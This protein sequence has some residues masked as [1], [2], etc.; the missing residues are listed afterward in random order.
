VVGNLATN[1]VTIRVEEV[2]RLQS[3]NNRTGTAVVCA[4]GFDNMSPSGAE[5]GEER[6]L[7]YMFYR[8][9]DDPNDPVLTS[10]GGATFQNSIASNL[11]L[12]AEHWVSP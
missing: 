5:F 7:G 4:S 9:F 1:Y 6:V 10:D 8:D 11:N 3:L 2:V 12:H